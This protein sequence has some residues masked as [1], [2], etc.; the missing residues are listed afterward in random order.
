[1]NFSFNNF[2]KHSTQEDEIHKYSCHFLGIGCFYLAYKDVIKEGD[3][4][5]ILECWH[6]LLP[7]FHNSK[8][9]NYS[10]EAL[11]FLFQ[12]EY[13][14]PSQQTQRL[15]YSRFVNTKGA[16]GRNIP[17]VLHQEHLNRLCKDC[18]KGLGSNKTK[19]GITQCSK[20][21]GTLYDLLKNFDGS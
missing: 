18:V 21:L 9:R 1:M 16:R 19:Q 5:H 2:P 4:G 11:D 10:N 8:R 12:Y 13:D 3:S 6:Y 15:L 14:L 17:F 7:L 20:A